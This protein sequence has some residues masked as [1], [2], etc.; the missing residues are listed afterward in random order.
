[1]GLGAHIVE[2]GFYNLILLLFGTFCRQFQGVFGWINPG[3][4]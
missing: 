3:N 1:M 2:L 4:N